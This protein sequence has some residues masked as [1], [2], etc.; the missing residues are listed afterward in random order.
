M[1]QPRKRQDS[2]SWF[3]VQRQGGLHLL[4][5]NLPLLAVVRRWQTDFGNKAQLVFL[6]AAAEDS[7]GRG[8]EMMANTH[9]QLS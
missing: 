1:I 9:W 8:V 2:P 4:Q 6:S 5:H 3:L 7:P